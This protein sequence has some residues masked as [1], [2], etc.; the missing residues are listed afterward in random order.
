MDLFVCVSNYLFAGK[1]KSGGNKLAI[2]DIC[3]FF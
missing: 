2:F 3:Y 1:A